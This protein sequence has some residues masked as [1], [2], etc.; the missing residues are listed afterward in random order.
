MAAVPAAAKAEERS[1]EEETQ[2]HTSIEQLFS[3]YLGLSFSIF[4]SLLPESTI[5]LLP[6]LQA[7]NRYLLLR[8]HQAEDHLAQLKSRR[9]EDSKAN[10]RVVEIFA[11]HRNSW[12]QEER[13]LL[14]QIDDSTEEIARL[15]PRVAE[16]ERN[17]ECLMGEVEEL[18]RE[19]AERDELLNFMSRK[20]A[21]TTT[22]FGE[23]GGGDSDNATFGSASGGEYYNGGGC[24]GSAG[25]GEAEVRV[26]EEE[27]ER[28]GDVALFYAHS[29][30]GGF[31]SNFLSSGSK[32]WPER[33]SLWQDVK[34]EPPEPMYQMKHFVARRESPWKVEG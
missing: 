34:Y 25:G 7:R 13:R 32:F 28:G 22:V 19:V 26:V 31:D 5:S 10:A 8:L 15:R 18:K 21:T 1:K 12:Q 17:E 3:S 29:N 2:K 24:G 11:S 23:M 4:L 20:T 14:Q 16:L 27:R 33:A 30:S 9:Q 6:T